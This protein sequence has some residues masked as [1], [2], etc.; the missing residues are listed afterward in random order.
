MME[1]YFFVRQTSSSRYCARSWSSNKL[2]KKGT[3]PSWNASINDIPLRWAFLYFEKAC[4]AWTYLVEAFHWKAQRWPR[5]SWVST[6][7]DQRGFRK[8][9]LNFGS[10]TATYMAFF[11]AGLVHCV[12]LYSYEIGVTSI[13]SPLAAGTWNVFTNLCMCANRVSIHTYF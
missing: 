7:Q 1:K 4:L 13:F 12:Y 10:A 3:Y 6:S 8:Q 11:K 9:R 2:R 5:S